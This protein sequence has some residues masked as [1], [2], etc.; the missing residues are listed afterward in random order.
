MNVTELEVALLRAKI[1]WLEKG[2]AAIVR[3]FKDGKR[4][5]SLFDDRQQADDFADGLGDSVDAMVSTVSSWT[6]HE[7]TRVSGA[8]TPTAA[9]LPATLEDAVCP[10]CGR[11]PRW[12][13]SS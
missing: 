4:H 13:S 2:P 12:P 1:E 11:H 9:A 7:D 5:F 10:K 3:W 6:Y 8:P